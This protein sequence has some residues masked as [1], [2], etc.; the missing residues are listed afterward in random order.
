MRSLAVAA[1]SA[2]AVALAANA[3]AAEHTVLQKEKRFEPSTLSV[4]A[5]DTL[6]FRNDDG[7]VHNVYSTTGG[8]EFNSGAQ[9]PGS[10]IKVKFDKGGKVSVRCAM[11]PKMKL[12]V[13]VK[14]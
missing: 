10:E 8:H 7:I 2:A 6:V 13:T 4:K 14:D 5:G 1:V 11:H 9:K 3:L 12:S